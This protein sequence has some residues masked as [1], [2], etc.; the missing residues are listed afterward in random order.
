MH[1]ILNFNSRRQ[2]F[3]GGIM[4]SVIISPNVVQ[5]TKDH[6][7]CSTM[8]GAIL[9]DGGSA[10]SAGSHWERLFFHNEYMTAQLMT[11]MVMSNITLA[12]FEDSGWYT[13]NYSDP[14][15]MQPLYYGK[16]KGCDFVNNFC[17][18]PGHL[19][20]EFC[21]VKDLEGC[22]M[23]GNFKSSCATDQ[24]MLSDGCMY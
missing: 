15:L 3:T 6:F 23:D 17:G 24:F 16:N 11:E 20:S 4:Q 9:E 21:Y 1:I 8:Q 10:S 5:A 18:M 14:S 2:S 13:I 19:F 22:S 7:N 12:L